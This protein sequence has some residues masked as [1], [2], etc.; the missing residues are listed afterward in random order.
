MAMPAGQ[1]FL[2]IGMITRRSLMVLENNLTFT[3]YVSRNYDDQFARSGAKI[4]ATLN[5]RLPAQ[6][7]VNTTGPAFGFSG[8]GPG[9]VIEQQVPLVLSYQHHVDMNFTA[10]DLTLSI[11]DFSERIIQPAIAS[12]ANEIDRRG[13]LLYTQVANCVG[14]FT[15]AGVGMPPGGIYGATNTGQVDTAGN[16]LFGYG[17]GYVLMDNEATPRDNLRSTIISPNAQNYAVAALS[18]LFHATT[19]IEEQYRSGNMG[20]SGGSKYS[21]DQNVAVQTFGPLGGVPLTAAPLPTNGGTSV[22]S[23][24]WT[25]TVNLNVGDVFTMAGVYAVNPQSR[26]STGQ[27]RQF[28]VTQQF[29]NTAGGGTINFAPAIFGPSSPVPEPRQNVTALPASGVA[30]TPFAPANATAAQMLAFHRDA[31]AVASVDLEMPGGVDMAARVASRKL[32][33]SLRL[34]RQYDINNDAFPCRVDCL[35]GWVA[36][37][38]VMAVR[39]M[40]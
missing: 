40:G 15:A 12:L 36:Q 2:T 18:G 3:K 23:S 39:I 10:Q 33:F 37:R 6:Y 27:L 11:D 16:A 13:L 32:G 20:I 21:M 19:E 31:F 25:G 38:P 1:T 7:N 4:G 34:V 8:S 9:P 24:G 35:Y 14:H 26:V 17:Q 30:I 29:T 28:V 22:G 5:L